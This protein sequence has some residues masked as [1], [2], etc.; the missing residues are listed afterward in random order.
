MASSSSSTEPVTGL[1]TGEQGRPTAAE[2]HRGDELGR[3]QDAQSS[4]S[5]A[6][7]S[8]SSLF[9][10]LTSPTSCAPSYTSLPLPNE[11]TVQ[12][13][14]RRGSSGT[15]S[16][17]SGTYMRK[18]KNMIL[19]LY[20][21]PDDVHNPIYDR[22]GLVVGELEMKC[23]EGVLAVSVKLE[24]RVTLSV[25]GVGARLLRTV[26]EQ[27]TV[28]W[29][30]EERS[31]RR[32]PGTLSFSLRLPVYF[33]DEE[34]RSWRLP[35]SL[36]PNYINAHNMFVRS[37]YTLSI[38]LTRVVECPVL[39]RVKEKTYNVLLELRPRN[40]PTGAGPQFDSTSI[41]ASIKSSLDE[42][43]Q[44]VSRMEVTPGSRLRPV[45]CHFFVPSN[46]TYC[47]S[48]TIPFHIQISSSLGTIRE[49]FPPSSAL[50][51]TQARE[52]VV[53]IRGK[54]AA[55]TVSIGSGKLRPVPP[56]DLGVGG[57]STPQDDMCLE[58]EGDVKCEEKV[59]SGGFD[60]GCLDVKDYIVLVLSPPSSKNPQLIGMQLAQPVKFVTD[61]W[62][63]NETVHP[64]DYEA[65]R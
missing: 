23:P 10:A 52:I 33:E 15:F 11:E 36:E 50:L 27:P 21:Q 65:R 28:L 14:P 31:T 60:I 45:E 35:P 54:K 2:G 13:T 1:M 24:G 32:C 9:Y 20:G 26:E 34:G 4:P 64:H 43:T 62:L 3:L 39:S 46:P 5:S 8:S 41:L 63:E 29:E 16:T 44:L 22:H 47:L 53:K 6:S 51:E 55:K 57:A 7:L 30:K 61:P 59:T 42:W 49:L 19:T 18:W 40:R 48:S 37:T 58:W 56:T 12:Y 25:N 17:G 38:S